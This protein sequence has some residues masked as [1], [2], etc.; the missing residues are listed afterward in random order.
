MFQLC[1]GRRGVT[2]GEG[3]RGVYYVLPR[4]AASPAVNQITSNYADGIGIFGVICVCV[5]VCWALSLLSVAAPHSFKTSSIIAPLVNCVCVRLMDKAKAKTENKKE[6]E[7]EKEKTRKRNEK[8][9]KFKVRS[10]WSQ[11][12]AKFK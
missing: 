3:G 6:S 8:R 1:R 4:A 9:L 5:C 11:I 10:S 2:R 7:N 12:G